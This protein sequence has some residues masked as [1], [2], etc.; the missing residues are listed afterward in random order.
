MSWLLDTNVLSELHRLKPNARVRAWVDAQVESDL[1]IS[2]ICLAELQRGAVLL[3]DSPKRRS[4][5]AWIHNDLVFRFAGRILP[6]DERVA[7]VWGNM[8]SAQQMK[9]RG[10]PVLDSLLAATALAH[11]LTLTTRNTADVKGLG[12]DLLNPWTD[13]PF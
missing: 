9:G 13:I 11:Q 7:F 6:I 8:V 1:F 5:L 12:V 4:L 2:A 3:P 10:L